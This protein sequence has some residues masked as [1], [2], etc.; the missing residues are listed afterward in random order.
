[1]RINMVIGG[2]TVAAVGLTLTIVEFKGYRLATQIIKDLR[3]DNP[4]FGDS[5]APSIP[6]WLNNLRLAKIM[7]VVGIILLLAGIGVTIY[8]LFTNPREDEDLEEALL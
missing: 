3:W 4:L 8:G 2:G 5:N 6:I 7:L 1:M